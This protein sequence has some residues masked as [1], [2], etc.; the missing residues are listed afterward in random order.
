MM[1]HSLDRQISKCRLEKNNKYVSYCSRP[2]LPEPVWKPAMM[3]I[4]PAN[5]NSRP[6]NAAA[7]NATTRSYARPTKAQL[8]TH[9]AE[10]VRRQWP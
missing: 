1:R 4:I 3:S 2:I 6:T 9:T 5:N 10:L 7:V 8:Q